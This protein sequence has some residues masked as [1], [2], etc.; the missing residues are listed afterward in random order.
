MR[1]RIVIGVLWGLAFVYGWQFWAAMYGLPSVLGP[2]L[3]LAIAGAV[4]LTYA[5]T[6]GRPVV[7]RR[8][9]GDV[10]DARVVDGG[11]FQEPQG[12]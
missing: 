2:I 8:I 3:A 6:R 1:K 7:K 4:A 12:R 10:P 5:P 11:S 9:L